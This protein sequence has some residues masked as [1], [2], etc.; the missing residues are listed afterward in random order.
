MNDIA[1]IPYR[2][3][4]FDRDGNKLSPD[5]PPVPPSTTDLF[6]VSHGWNN[7]KVDARALYQGLF[8]NF[9]A[10]TPPTL[11]EAR[12]LA[13]VGVVWPSKRFDEK[14]AVEAAS[15]AAG[16]GAAL[17]PAGADP[18][19]EEELLHRLETLKAFFNHPDQQ[20]VLDEAKQLVPDLEKKGSAR[21]QFVEKIRTLLNRDAA[22][23]EDA[24][25]IFFRCDPE[26][27]ME[28]LRISEEDVETEVMSGG[29][30]AFNAPGMAAGD[31]GGAAGIAS[32]LKGFKAAAMNVLNFTTYYE[33]KDRGGKVGSLGV[34]K[35]IDAVS[36]QVER[37]H[38]VGHSFGGRVVTAA[39]AHSTTNKIRSMTLLQ[40]AFSHNAFSRSMGGLFRSVV[41]RQRVRGPIVITHTKN[42]KAVG[43]AYPIA[44]RLAGQ[45][46][47]ALGD[48]N[49]KYG[50]LGRNGAQKMNLGETLPGALLD[51]GKP[52]SFASG[53]FFNLES[54][55]FIK[56][57]SDVAGPQVAYLAAMAS[58]GFKE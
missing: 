36:D 4:E 24:S 55:P 16:G 29:G 1:G 35:L 6:V 22:D 56:D 52:Y 40:A 9:M 5:A 19:S 21:E 23:K 8:T 41:E 57:H 43:L 32:F 33:M 28:Q 20:K 50:G 34:A 25:D 7:N 3:V 27:L 47:A 45:I 15:E 30:A 39:A 44:S 10:V 37:I 31:S 46:A 17:G 2:E 53:K 18:K 48:E 13:I 51:V 14:I 26:D 12:K 38:L 49:D 11:L 42:D 54:S 58:L